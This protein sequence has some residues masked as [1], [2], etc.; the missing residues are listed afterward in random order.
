MEARVCTVPPW[1]VSLL[2]HYVFKWK[3]MFGS[4]WIDVA[5]A[6][7]IVDRGHKQVGRWFR[8]WVKQRVGGT[9]KWKKIKPV[10]ESL[11]WREKQLS[12]CEVT[13]PKLCICP[14]KRC[15]LSIRCFLHCAGLWGHSGGWRGRAANIHQ[16]PTYPL[17]ESAPGLWQPWEL[18]SSPG[19]CGA[20]LSRG[21]FNCR[22][23]VS[24]LFWN[25]Y[26]VVVLFLF[27]LSITTEIL[28]SI[29]KCHFFWS[30]GAALGHNVLLT[31]RTRVEVIWLIPPFLSSSHFPTL[32]LWMGFM[33]K[34]W[35]ML[36][37]ARHS[38]WSP[39][40][41]L[42]LPSQDRPLLSKPN[43]V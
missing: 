36:S 20:R 5:G 40:K 27:L 16:V 19:K 35:K 1:S 31:Q 17:P 15:F 43:L 37:V 14:L 32:H 42:S 23:T 10:L 24:R 39:P 6:S 38:F 25:L 28:I 29:V 3:L 30:V 13:P 9:V 33:S 2:K 26:P 7:S 11:T 22:A 8:Q 4:S 21:L 12:I 34:L 41:I 18:C